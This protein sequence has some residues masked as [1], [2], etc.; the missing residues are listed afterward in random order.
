VLFKIKSAL[1]LL[2]SRV[3][4]V[5]AREETIEILR[6]NV[7]ILTERNESL[8]T[9]V[10]ES[11]DLVS[12]YKQSMLQMR[13]YMLQMRDHMEEQDELYDNQETNE[14]DDVDPFKLMRKKET[15]H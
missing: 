1:N 9:S 14:E 5:F 11:L 8:K 10:V 6:E 7:D 4:Y 15:I 13:E 12:S 2:V 3:R